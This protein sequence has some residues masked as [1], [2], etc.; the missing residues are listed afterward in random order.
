MKEKTYLKNRVLLAEVKL[1][2]ETKKAS[3]KLVE[4][5]ILMTKKISEKFQFNSYE[6]RQDTLQDALVVLLRQWHNFDLKYTNAFAYFTEIIKR[7]FALSYNYRTRL[8]TINDIDS[9]Y[10]I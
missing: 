4:Y 3:D 1:C 10:N 5:F 8:K 9:F 7:S 6:D 2:L